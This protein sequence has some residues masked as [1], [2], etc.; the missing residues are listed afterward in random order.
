MRTKIVQPDELT[1]K[2]LR[3]SDYIG[4]ERRTRKQYLKLMH[5]Y[6]LEA[7]R[8]AARQPCQPNNCGSVCLCGP[9]SARKALAH[10]DPSWRR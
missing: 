6:R 3:A 7:L 9:C 5:S 10:F 1:T 2:T 4:V 8:W